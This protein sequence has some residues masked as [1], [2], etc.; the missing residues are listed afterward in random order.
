MEKLGLVRVDRNQQYHR[1]TGVEMDISADE[2]GHE[3]RCTEFKP[4]LKSYAP[5]TEGK[6]E[7]PCGKEHC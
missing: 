5:E 7:C 2:N 1:H 3:Y 6:H 4:K